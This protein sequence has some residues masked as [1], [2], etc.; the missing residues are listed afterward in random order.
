MRL[1][2]RRIL[3]CFLYLKARNEEPVTSRKVKHYILK[4]EPEIYS[5]FG[6][7]DRNIRR[8]L[9]ELY[10]DGIL[11]RDMHNQRVLMYTLTT[12]G[13]ETALRYL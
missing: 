13:F 9:R 12:K 5:N 1:V 2:K 6:S 7:L 4:Q 8:S 10:M 3:E 11:E